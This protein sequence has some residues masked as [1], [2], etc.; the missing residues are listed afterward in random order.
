MARKASQAK[1]K[2]PVTLSDDEVRS[3]LLDLVRNQDAPATVATILKGQDKALGR[4]RA[5]LVGKLETLHGSGAIHRYGTAK[6]PKYHHEAPSAIVG[7]SIVVAAGAGPMSWADLKK[8][9]V[10]KADARL[11]PA[12]EL[13]AIRDELVQAG[14]IHRWPRPTPKGIER[15]A[16]SPPDPTEYLGP[17]LSQFREQLKA[18]AERLN[19]RRAT[20]D[21][22]E[23]AAGRVLLRLGEAALEFEGDLAPVNGPSILNAMS[24]ADPATSTGAP[25]TF[26]RLRPLLDGLLPSKPAF[27]AAVLELG[28]QGLVSLHRH[29]F[30]HGLSEAEREQMVPDGKGGYYFTISRRASR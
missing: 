24:Q 1:A 13:D 29:D 16:T 20:A 18:L 26:D 2:P 30:P 11:V 19:S 6:T 28:K 23:R 8:R 10:L 9:P 7:R 17:L 4:P 22:L 12:R 21:R 14:K 15:F 3:R 27:D 25:I 5:E